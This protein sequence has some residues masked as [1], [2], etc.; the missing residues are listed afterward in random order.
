MG[1][2]FKKLNQSPEPPGGAF[3][4]AAGSEMPQPKKAAAEGVRRRLPRYET[5]YASPRGPVP[6]TESPNEKAAAEIP[7]DGFGGAHPRGV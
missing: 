2:P 5:T 3:V 1:G 6:R 4:A 7:S